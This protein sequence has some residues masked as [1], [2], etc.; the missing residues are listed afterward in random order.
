ML[1]IHI[2]P[3]LRIERDHV[4]VFEPFIQGFWTVVQPLLKRF[5]FFNLFLQPDKSLL[6]IGDLLFTDLR[7]VFKTDEVPQVLGL[8]L[9]F[10]C[11]FRVHGRAKH[12]QHRC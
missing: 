5:D 4:A 2:P 9:L 10:L 1:E 7:L 3:L 12:A 8:R 11:R 6:H